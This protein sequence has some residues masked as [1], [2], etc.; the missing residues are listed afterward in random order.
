VKVLHTI[1]TFAPALRWGGPILALVGLAQEQARQGHQVT[2]LTT[3]LDVDGRLDVPLCQPVTMDGVEVWYCRAAMAGHLDF[4]SFTSRF[5]RERIH[6]FDIVHVHSV[7]SWTPTITAFWALRRDVPYILRPAGALGSICL[8]KSY[9]KPLKSSISRAKKRVYFKTLARMVLERASAL[10]FCTEQEKQEASTL[11]L[12]APQVVVPLGVSLAPGDIKESDPG[13]R[14]RFSVLRNRPIVLYLSR[15]D[16]IKGLDLLIE[17]LGSLAKRGYEFGFVVAGDGPEAYRRQVVSFIDR[18]GIAPFTFFLGPIFGDVKQEI[19]READ[20]FALTSYHENFGIAVLEA[21]NAGLPVVISNN[22]AIHRE[23]TRAGAGLSTGLIQ[24]EIAS[25]LKQLLDSNALR[26][27]MGS[28]GRELVAERF[29]W[30]RAVQA[31]SEVYQQV[32]S[33]GNP[34]RGH[35]SKHSVDLASFVEANEPTGRA[36]QAA[37]REKSW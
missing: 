9:E 35:S 13:L 22:V 3:D 18:H 23:I 24:D 2:V 15:L 37:T 27:Q 7:F 34:G 20:L 19:L 21:M 25:A 32:I 11:G 28:R 5:L 14:E 10:H 36:S 12:R 16:P 31:L 4:S 17:A 26:N 8:A 1:P 29:A 30:P 6:T 33:A